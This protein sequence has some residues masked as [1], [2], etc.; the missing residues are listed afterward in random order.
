MNILCTYADDHC[1]DS[2]LPVPVRFILDDFG[3]NCRIEGF[4]NMIS[5][6]RSREISA[7]IILQSQSQPLSS[8]GESAHTIIDN[9]DT[10]IYMGGNDA[11]TARIIADRSNKH[12]HRIHDMPIG[13]NRIFCRGE[14]PKFSDTVDITG[15]CS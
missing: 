1:K 11:E 8:C 12:V 13:T 5:N 4:E 10:M 15:F 14:K 3:T 7:M 2:R 6:I 9:C